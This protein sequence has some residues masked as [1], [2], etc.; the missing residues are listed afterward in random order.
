MLPCLRAFKQSLEE[1]ERSPHTIK[2][3]LSDLTD[4]AV[5]FEQTN[6]D[7]L[8]PERITPTDLREYKRGLVVQRK[9]KPNTVNRKLATLR[10]FLGWANQTVEAETGF[11][12]T[13]VPKVP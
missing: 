3:Y 1:C 7:T 10:A 5:W 4:F 12:P 13:K 8:T 11:N 6:G 9:L 2:N